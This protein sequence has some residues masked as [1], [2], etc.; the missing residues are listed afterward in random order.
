MHIDLTGF[1]KVP[2][3]DKSTMTKLPPTKIPPNHVID[4]MRPN[5]YGSIKLLANYKSNSSNK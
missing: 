1:N 3:L 5:V 2:T 4:K